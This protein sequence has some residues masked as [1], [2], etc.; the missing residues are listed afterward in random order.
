MA[1]KLQGISAIVTGS[2]SGNGRAIALALSAEGASVLCSDLNAEPLKG[3]YYESTKPTHE[4][5]VANGGRASFLKANAAVTED[6]QAL[7][8]KAVELYGRLDVFVANAGIFCGLN[9]IENESEEA[10]D[11]TMLVNA[12]GVF[13]AN[14]YAIKQ[15]VKQDI[16]PNGTRG[17]IIN[18]ASIGGLVGL[19]QESSYCMSKGAVAQLTRQVAL[20]YAP[21][22]IN[23]NAVCPGFLQTAMVRPFI[24]DEAANKMLHDLTP[25]GELGKAEDVAKACVFLASEDS[26]WMTGSMLTVD[27]GYTCR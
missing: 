8:A 11:K 14:K 27:G 2:S 10:Y 22:K 5:I 6:V 25:F 23:V 4:E 20:D 13:L 24:E 1:P 3:G 21:Q 19:A 7:V 16:G 26:R 18:I 12:K 9:L 15:F 17:K